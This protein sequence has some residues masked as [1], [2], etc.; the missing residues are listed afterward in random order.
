[1]KRSRQALAAVVVGFFAGPVSAECLEGP[2]AAVARIFEA[3][4][5]DRSGTLTPAEYADANLERF[6]VSFEA[7]DVNSDG[8]TSLAEYLV[9]YDVH[10]P[11]EGGIEL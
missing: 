3:A 10:H 2:H 7:S 9:L 6:G 8:E 4:D 11:S 1:M 5:R